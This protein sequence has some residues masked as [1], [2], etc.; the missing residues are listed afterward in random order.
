[1]SDVAATI[2]LNGDAIAVEGSG[3]TATG[4]IVTI[5]TVGVY[6]IRGTLNNG[7]IVVETADEGDVVLLFNGVDI[8]NDSSAPVYVRNADN[9]FI[10]LVDGT[11]NSVT[12]GSNY[13]F[14]DAETDEPNAAIFSHDDLT[15]NGGGALTVNGNYNHGIYGKDD[16]EISGGTITINA[17]NDGIKGR[18]SLVVQS[19]IITINAEGDGLQSNNDEEAEKGY[20]LIAG[21]TLNI[22][23]AEDAI[24]AETVL[25]VSG[26]NLVLTT[27]GG[28][29]YSAADSA[30]GLKAGVDLVI[31]GGDIVIDAAD[32][33]IHSNGTMSIDGATLQLASGDDGIHAD[34]SIQI[35]SGTINIS[36]SYEGIESAIIIING[37]DIQLV[38]SDDGINVAGGADSSAFNGRPGQNQF[39][40]LS[41]YYLQINGGYIYVDASGDGLD[42]NG[43]IEMNGGVV[44][45]NG[46]TAN[47]NGP[48]DYDGGFSMTG[49]YLVAVGS[50][51]M[52]QAPGTASTQNSVIYN[53]ASVQS[54]GTIVHIQ[55]ASGNDMLTFAPLREYQSVVLSSPALQSGETY[56]VYVGGSASG[57]ENNGLYTDGTYSGGTAVE[58][59]TISSVVTSA[60]V[61]T[62]G[63]GGGRP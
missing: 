50:A 20:V 48:L 31:T 16:V 57:T 60:G 36:Q 12:D 52:A 17:V 43:S 37:G 41:N 45:V 19:G 34:A 5:D 21:G 27:G 46:P 33:A 9:V 13:V 42:A 11:T 3:A 1:M 39:A 22:T 51:G 61:A 62:R 55:D 38:A 10:T 47:N 53:F 26:G 28:S 58:S 14:P 30:K 54:A 44:L 2:T 49:G 59:F 24:Q 18:D 6:N 23:A 40:D 4:A 7:Q 32:D 56:T 35:N 15:I 8:T 29:S 63:F 25:T